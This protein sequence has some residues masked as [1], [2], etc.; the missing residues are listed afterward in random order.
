MALALSPYPPSPAPSGSPRA[1]SARAVSKARP[2][3]EPR[4][5]RG[6]RQSPKPAWPP[7]SSFP[8]RQLS[9]RALCGSGQRAHFPLA[10]RSGVQGGGHTPSQGLCLGT[11]VFQL[12][13]TSRAET[14]KGGDLLDRQ[15]H[16]LEALQER[17][18][19]GVERRRKP[20]P[21]R[22]RPPGAINAARAGD[23]AEW[24]QASGLRVPLSLGAHPAWRPVQAFIAR[25]PRDVAG[26]T[27]AASHKY[28]AS[29]RTIRVYY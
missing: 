8:P 19:K 17:T 16:Q 6:S 14:L 18:S 25:L 2:V 9:G 27:E 1:R 12:E 29:Q 10:A 22:P 5:A 11:R 21:A 7:A 28:T 26:L 3:G 23:G 4:K 20:V 15:R 24:G 13:T